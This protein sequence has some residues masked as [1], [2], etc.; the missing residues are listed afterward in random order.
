MK[1]RVA[2]ASNYAANKSK[3]CS[4]VFVMENYDIFGLPETAS[5]KSSE[6]AI[7]PQSS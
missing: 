7:V 3:H 5:I 1:Y 6:D 4:I 2:Y